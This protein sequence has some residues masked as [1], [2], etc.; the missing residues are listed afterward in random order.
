MDQPLLSGRIKELPDEAAGELILRPQFEYELDHLLPFYLILEIASVEEAQ[1]LGLLSSEQAEM[2]LAALRAI[3]AEDVRHH[4]RSSMMDLSFAL[5]QAVAARLPR[6]IPAWHADK[7]RNDFQASAQRMFARQKVLESAEALLRVSRALTD[8]SERTTDLPMLAY[9]HYQAAQIISPGFYLA[10][11]NEAV[12]GTVQRLLFTYDDINKSPLGAG[13]IAGLEWSWDRQRMARRSGFSGPVPSA[14]SSVADRDWALKVSFEFALFGNAL[15]RFCTDFLHWGSS[16]YHFINLPDALVSISSAMPQKKNFTIFERLRGETAHL[17]A[18]HF[19][20]FLGQRNTPYTN[21]VETSKEAGRYLILIF[22]HMERITVL[23]TL[24]LEHLEFLAEDMRRAC[25]QE[26]HAGFALA[27]LLTLQDQIPYRTAQVIAGSSISN[28]INRHLTPAQLPVTELEAEARKRGYST[29]ISQE[30]LEQLFDVEAALRSKRSDGSTH[31]EQVRQMLAAQKRRR[32]RLSACW[33]R[34]RE[35][36]EAALRR[37][38]SS[39]Q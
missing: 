17:I 39:S 27:N 13:A 14:L 16:A 12:L 21:L 26:F 8:L 20:F 19:D 1:R 10:S 38:R 30:Q 18:F 4:M 28:A 22:Q 7:S 5:E 29:N 9:T 34:R 37:L 33:Q 2:L 23:L 31:P 25:E 24:V 36:V 15:S 35:R 11:M 6:E 3:R 32:D